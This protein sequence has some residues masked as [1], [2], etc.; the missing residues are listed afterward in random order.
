MPGCRLL[1]AAGQR[2]EL[3]RG[4]RP[5][6]DG[7]QRLELDRGRRPGRDG[8]QRLE[9]AQ[10]AFDVI[11]GTPAPKL[12]VCYV[13]GLDFRRVTSASTPYLAQ[14]IERFPISRL[15]NLPSNELFPTLV[16]GMLPPRHGVWGVRLA[17][18]PRRA[19][20]GLVDR[21]PDSVAT[22]LQC[23]LHWADRRFDL[24]AVP[25]RRRR[26]LSLTRTKYKRRTLRPEALFGIG[27]ART[28]FDLVG[29]NQSRY[30]FSASY[31]PEHDVLPR[32]ARGDVVLEI[33]ELY[34]LD[35]HQQWNLDRDD[36]TLRF[37]RVLDR[38]LERLTARAA[39]HD[40]AVLLVSD[41]GHERIRE[42]IDLERGLRELGIG[43]RHADWF[44]EVSN[45]RFW[46]H[47]EGAR[48]ALVE[49][50]RGL[51]NGTLL[52][53]EEMREHDVALEDGSYGE[54]FYYLDPGHIFFPHDFHHPLANLWLGLSDRLQ[55]NRLVDPR[56][57]GNH[58]H[59]P[60]FDVERCFATML[61][62]RFQCVR[63]EGRIVDVAPTI[64]AALGREIPDVMEGRPLFASKS[65]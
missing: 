20:D 27:G 1:S 2:A 31:R 34:S 36:E 63:P 3:D 32:V 57:R 22:T 7:G 52:T 49:W 9:S 35:R 47:D 19:A 60:H 25:P 4:R 55:R 51:G 54:L 50:L 38:F 12:H 14:A 64:L 45:A 26:R 21:L 56:H 39:E 48:R 11:H 17:P 8:G 16:T 15:R 24:A 42:S 61:D 43:A 65:G 6:R 29:G 37:Y 59:L 5:E 28:V 10:G 44:T 58:G 18:R 30:L 40:V 33:L 46:L 62:G 13:S 41:H 53:W 23:F